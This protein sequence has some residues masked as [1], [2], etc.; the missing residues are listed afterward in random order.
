MTI[1]FDKETFSKNI[2]LKPLVFIARED[3]S[4]VYEIFEE[5]M[6]ENFPSSKQAFP[7]SVKGF[8]L[9]DVPSS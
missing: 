3:Q 2:D 7:N 4:R 5:E 6:E 8:T 9:D 1:D